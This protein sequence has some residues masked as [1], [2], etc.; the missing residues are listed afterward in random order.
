MTSIRAS[1]AFL[2]VL[3][4]LAFTPFWACGGEDDAEFAKSLAELG[5]RTGDKAYFELARKVYK[6]VAD[7]DKRSEESRDLAR[8]GLADM[9]RMEAIGASANPAKT[10]AEVLALFKEAIETMEA[11]V[12]KNP[13]H[14]SADEAR[15]QV[16]TTRLGFVQ[17]AR[18]LLGDPEKREERGAAQG[19]VQ[20]D[21]EEMVRGAIGYFE[22][23][24]KGHDQMDATL[25]SQISQYYWVIC[26]YYLALVYEPGSEESRKALI[27]AAEQLEDFITLNDG[28]LLAIY[29]QDILGLTNWEQ[30]RATN[31]DDD[32]VTYYRQAV[33]W[34]GTCI[35][36]PVED[37]DSQRIVA[38][39]Y[40]HLGQ[41]CNEAGRIGST[42]FLRIGVTRLADMLTRHNTIWRQDNGI[43]AMLE[44]A[45]LE[46]A[47]DRQSEAI[48][49]ARQAG[50]YAKSLG[51]G[52]LERQAN[53]ILREIVSGSGSG[54][55][56][57][58]PGVLMR[59]ADDF[60]A[61]QKW[62]QAIAAYQQVIASVERTP[63]TA[64][65]FLLRSWRRMADSFRQQGDMVAAALALEPIH[66]IWA[67]GL[68]DRTTGG[69]NNTNLIDLGNT[70]LLAQSLWK[71]LHTATGAAMF[72]RRHT[73]IRDAFRTEYPEHP[74]GDAS[75][76]NSAMEK[77]RQA[78]E[79]LQ[80]K[81]SRWRTTMNETDELF[82]QVASDKNSQRQDT[83]WAFL[84]YTQYLREDWKGILKAV[85][86]AQTYWDSAEAKE[87][88]RQFESVVKRRLPERGKAI[89]WSAE[90]HYRLGDE[91]EDKKDSA[92]AKAHWAAILKELD[93]WH[94]EYDLLRNE[95]AKR[96]YAGALGHIVFAH[97]GLSDIPA[98]D[99]AFKRL[100]SED[101]TYSRLP[102]VTFA[103]ARHLNDQAK[104]I[105][106]DRKAARVEL[107]GTSEQ[108]G[109]RTRLR[110]V[111]KQDHMVVERRVDVEGGLV[112]A[113]ELVD[114]YE[115]KTAEGE[116]TK[117]PKAE[118]EETR[119]KLIPA[120]EAEIADLTER[121][122]KLRAERE[123]LEARA[124]EL[125]EI[126]KA[127]AQALYEPLTRAANYFWEWDQALKLNKQTRDPH[128]ISIFADLYW[129]A[130]LLRE[131]E[132][133]NWERS[134]ELYEDLLTFDNADQETKHE[135]LGRL[136][137]IYASLATSADRGTD[138]R[139][140][141]VARALDRLQG[142]LALIPENNDLVVSLLKG[143]TVVIPYHFAELN[144]YEYFPFPRVSSVDEFKTAVDKLG[145]P[146]G[147]PQPKFETDAEERAYQSAINSFRAK[148]NGMT[149]AAL[150]RTVQGF[151]G[152]G[153]DM[154]LY[155]RLARSGD[156]FRLALGRVYVESGAPEH[157]MKAYNLSSSL[158]SGTWAAEENGE[159]WWAAQVVRLSARVTGAE[160]EARTAGPAD[161]LS[162]T[163]IDWIDSASMILRGVNT[164][165]PD[166]GDDER[167]RTRDQFKAL[168]GRI[169]IL[170]TRAGMSGMDDVYLNPPIR[171]GN[172]NGNG[173][174]KK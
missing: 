67:D 60:F 122:N 11:F 106:T 160:I 145:K 144:R 46:R 110:T 85:D 150:E 63:Q 58:D 69:K 143:E 99:K 119:D 45:K 142:S 76:W 13:D 35:D 147:P 71:D 19:T 49:I 26:Q 56:T 115:K 92:T 105:D 88:E 108:E 153:F 22:K 131:E 113:R 104:V 24:R 48:D 6:T 93:G 74:S 148:V 42:N 33:E 51:K 20:R 68:V 95:D 103:L 156:D 34:F 100:L 73:E 111:T 64:Q 97:I 166:L 38:N 72:N 114:V 137:S 2:A 170:R 164:T 70:R 3:L 151:D 155:K 158:L 169:K 90:A 126:I 36:T 94:A 129:K 149:P 118:Y 146:G 136:G 31:K 87:Q 65:D 163:A 125:V 54:A 29:A 165:N 17:W 167:P 135:A 10:Y 83:A 139:A 120:M 121:G 86:A 8:Y 9:T 62:A 96:Y 171:S 53:R 102:K 1:F 50:E 39:G 123:Q 98:A 81:N 5:T 172:G 132:M 66:D 61:Q 52:W 59:V 161:Q 80:A 162:P 30:A 82:K 14:P 117:I 133:Q 41:V 130:G 79:Q 91:A 101:P 138:E 78:V 157:M 23:L 75:I 109:V 116:D 7:D 25:M 4:A 140:D 57:A 84:I 55:T 77:F 47:R 154:R 28:Q 159:T 152:A 128:N 141:L 124:G 27:Y 174:E 89:F 107:N 44:L 40:F 127:K 173:N 134:K 21:A 16:G 112:K 18:D 168:F 32:R 12:N 15:L 37:L 43:R